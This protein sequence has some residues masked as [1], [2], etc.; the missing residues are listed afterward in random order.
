MATAVVILSKFTSKK[1]AGEIM[2]V[3]DAAYD[4]MQN[5]TTS[6]TQ[7]VT[8]IVADSSRQCWV[9]AATGAVRVLAGSDPTVTTSTG[10]YIPAGGSLTLGAAI[11]QKIAIIDAA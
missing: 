7:A 1:I 4:E 2:G 8:T 10:W 6:G 9:I 11:G 5:V 3:P